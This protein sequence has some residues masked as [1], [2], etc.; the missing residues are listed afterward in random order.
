M[1]PRRAPELLTPV[2]EIARLDFVRLLAAETVAEALARLREEKVGERIV[3]FYVTDEDGR[4]LGV[5]PTRRL[6]LSAESARIRDIMVHPVI[7]IPDSTS[8]GEALQTL[9]DK[10][11]LA[12]PV[13]DK[14]GRLYGVLDVSAITQDLVDLERRESAAEAFQLAGIHIEQSR[15]RNP[16]GASADRLPW[17]MC[18][19]ASGIAAAVISN[20]FNHLLQAVVAL[21]FFVPL[22][23]TLAESTAMQSLA[24]TLNQ[25][26]SRDRTPVWRGVFR[27]MKIG[28]ILGVASGLIVGIVGVVWLRLFDVVA[29]VAG[30]I[31]MAG[32][33]G[34]TLGATVPR[35][36]RRWNLN[37]TIASGPVTLAMTDV[38][39]L[40][41]YFGLAALVLT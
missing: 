21:A 8:F 33:L 28:L 36:V 19:I 31:L 41:A 23:L 3:Y 12:L 2:R 30:G 39:A 22:L 7:S 17:L 26:L 16:F 1:E 24:T 5:V 9:T 20:Q 4:L 34:A 27:E 10:R 32:A 11:L 29:V 37:P 15:L 13:L 14:S 6:L 38:A 18:N 40:S 35:L 25:S